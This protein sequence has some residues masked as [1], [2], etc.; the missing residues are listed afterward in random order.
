SMTGSSS[1]MRTLFFFADTGTGLRF[2]FGLDSEGFSLLVGR[3]APC[4]P[5][6][7]RVA[8]ECPPYLHPQISSPCA[9]GKQRSDAGQSGFVHKKAAS[10][11]ENRRDRSCAFILV[12]DHHFLRRNPVTIPTRRAEERIDCGRNFCISIC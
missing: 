3:G 5:S 1:T 7:A 10:V 2:I 6:P 11:S 12:T 4:A 9:N 8:A